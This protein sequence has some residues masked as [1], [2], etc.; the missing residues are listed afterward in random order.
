[1][2]ALVLAGYVFRPWEHSLSFGESFHVGVFNRG[3]DSRLVCFSHSKYPYFGSIIGIVDA[4]GNIYPPLKRRVA[5]GDTWGVYYRYFQWSDSILWTLM[6]SL[7][8]PI[9][10]FATMPVAWMLRRLFRAGG[11]RPPTLK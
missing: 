8:Y 4:E 3:L 9:A 1:M 5:F 7:W 6:F 2:V 10:L 11:T